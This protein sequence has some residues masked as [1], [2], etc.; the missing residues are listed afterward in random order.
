MNYS[1]EL[2]EEEKEKIKMLQY[3]FDFIANL[4]MTDAEFEVFLEKVRTKYNYEKMNK[5]Q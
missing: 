2:T 3:I 1:E 4:D 5:V